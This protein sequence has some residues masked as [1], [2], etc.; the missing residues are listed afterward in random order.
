MKSHIYAE[1]TGDEAKWNEFEDKLIREELL[2]EIM[3]LIKP[4]LSQ[5]KSPLSININYD[6]NGNIAVTATRN[7]IQA[8]VPVGSTPSAYEEKAAY[9]EQ[10][11]TVSEPLL[12]D[13]P[14][15][16]EVEEAEEETPTTEEPQRRK[17]KSVGFSVTFGDGTH[18][19]E[20][21]AVQTWTKTLQKIGLDN[22]INNQRKHEAWHNVD[23]KNICIVDRVETVRTSDNASPQTLIDGYYVMTQLSNMQKVKDIESLGRLWP[24]LKIKVLWDEP[25]AQEDETSGNDIQDDGAND[26]TIK[27]LA[28]RYMQQNVSERTA[29]GYI[30]VLDNPVRRFIQDKIET[31]ADSIFSYTTA[32]DVKLVIDMLNSDNDFTKENETRHNSMTAA[33]SQYLKFIISRES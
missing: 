5:V 24:K 27:E 33:L 16:Q 4:T 1:G 20:R 25:T 10:A 9:P 31:S 28:R 8:S 2:P 7:C 12:S 15:E 17:K 3:E 32:E 26:Q 23:G 6:P 19:H 21:K 14:E 29:N 18:I 30:S 13:E 11:T 22:I